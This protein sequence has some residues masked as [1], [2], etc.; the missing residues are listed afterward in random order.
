MSLARRSPGAA[1]PI[2]DHEVTDARSPPRY[3]P[4]PTLWGGWAG[5]YPRREA[6]SE[7][8]D[9]DE[10][11]NR[12]AAHLH[13]GMET[14]ES[15]RAEAAALLRA[16][17]VDRLC[18]DVAMARTILRFGDDFHPIARFFVDGSPEQRFLLD[19]R[20]DDA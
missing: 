3:G 16:I 17:G 12:L 4:G 13:P 15:E 14:G 18:E 10:M 2:G 19:L 8:P 20:K 7:L 6:V 1:R 5:D 11:V 9:F